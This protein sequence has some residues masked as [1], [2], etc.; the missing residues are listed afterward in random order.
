MLTPE[1]PIKSTW[2]GGAYLAANRAKLKSVQVTRQ[3]YQEK[4]G[5][6]LAKVF[7]KAIS[8]SSES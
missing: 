7:S 8:R 5:A 4:G 3:E 2:R 1:S 6:W